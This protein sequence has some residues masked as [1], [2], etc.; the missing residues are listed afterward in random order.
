[1]DQTHESLRIQIDNWFRLER[2]RLDL[3]SQADDLREQAKEMQKEFSSVMKEQRILKFEATS[4]I[5]EL[6]E[7]YDVPTVRSWELFYDHILRNNAFELL[8]KRISAP[9]V[10]EHWEAGE[11]IPGVD[12]YPVDKIKVQA[13]SR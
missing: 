7:Q 9:A 11:H 13:I 4:C 10:R 2:K 3:Q 12:K 6:N 1:M 5:V 8:Q